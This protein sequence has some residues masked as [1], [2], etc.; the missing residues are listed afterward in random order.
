M[1]FIEYNK[2]IAEDMYVIRVKG[3]YKGQQGQF[4]MV[5]P[6]DKA[7]IIGRPISIH[8]IDNDGIEFMYK[9]LGKGSKALSN[10]KAFEEIDIKGPYGNGY[11]DLKNK[12]I[13][14]IGGGTGVAPL[15][16]LSKQLYKDNEIDI[17]LGFRKEELYFNKYEKYAN[18]LKFH[19][20][21]DI[22]KDLKLDKYDVV[23][24]CGPEIMQEKIYEICRQKN[25]M[26]YASL[27]KHMA[28]G[29]GAC[30]VCTCDTKQ[31]NKRVCK[32][33]PVFKGEDVFF[34]E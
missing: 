24:S 10:L 30:L 3:N 34:I 18:K 21:N 25:I 5:K 11:P 23:L 1:P 16:L 27:E 22:T 4:Y 28:C 17:H 15:Y 19:I 13:A 9:I 29:I 33:G 20:G 31:G 14:L 7:I 2:K 8:N 12:K 26:H 6:V 32:D